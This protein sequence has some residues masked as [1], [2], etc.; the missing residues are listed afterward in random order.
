MMRNSIRRKPCGTTGHDIRLK[1]RLVCTNLGFGP[2]GNGEV[3]TDDP[4][5]FRRLPRLFGLTDLS[6]DDHEIDKAES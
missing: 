2:V 6:I 3:P 5:L 1:P 4:E